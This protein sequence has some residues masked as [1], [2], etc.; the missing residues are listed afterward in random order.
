[1]R[2]FQGFK[3]LR[4]KNWD[5][6]PINPSEISA[7]L[8]THAHL[9]HSGYIPLL[10]K[11]GYRG[12]VYCTSA[13][14]DLCALLLPDSGY[15]QQDEADFANRR[16]FSKHKPALPLYTEKD[17]RI[18]LSSLQMVDWRKSYP[19]PTGHSEN[20][21][22]EF[23]PAGHL[24]GA[25]SILLNAGGHTVAF[26]GDL[27]RVND[28]LT[29]TPDFTTGART[30]IVESTYGNRA[31]SKESPEDKLCKIIQM[32][33]DRGGTLLIPSFAVGRAQLILYYI[34]QLKQAG[35]IAEIP[36]YLNSPM[37]IQAN[38]VFCRHFDET[39][40]TEQEARDI[41]ATAKPVST[42]EE[43]IALN[44]RK[45]PMILIAASGMATGGRVLHHL[46]AFAPDPKNTILF[47][48]FQAGGT[49]GEAILNGAKEV[50]IHGELW[51]IRAQVEEIDTLSAHA[52]SDGIVQWVHQ[53]Q[54]KPQRIFVTHG[55]P[56][57]ADSLRHRLASDRN[58]DV[59][60][61]DLYQTVSIG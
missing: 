34:R 31:H 54:Q 40:V 12:P 43:S 26:S 15:L 58:C 2:P 8:L 6:F 41:C 14:R 52:D 24:L 19:V 33:H 42:V 23:H 48:G 18:S 25:A 37:A 28:P 57:A 29:R 49:R 53:L 9:D 60:V 35:R 36:V 10:V 20:I 55:E 51:P 17:A 38:G 44:E 13:T 27:G 56:A 3:N 39:K 11:N 47:V 5:P 16:G 21:Q 30:L 7:V 61:P 45:D 4:L 32:T 46:K 50:K 1:L 59:S 22:F